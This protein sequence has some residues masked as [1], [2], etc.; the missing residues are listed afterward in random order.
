MISTLNK[1]LQ[2]LTKMLCRWVTVYFEASGFG[3]FFF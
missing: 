2:I 3:D 1:V